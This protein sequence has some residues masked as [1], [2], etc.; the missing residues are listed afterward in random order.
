MEVTAALDG[1]WCR[2]AV[3]WGGFKRGWDEQKWRHEYKP[4]F[5]SVLL[6]RAREKWEVIAPLQC[7]LH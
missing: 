4:L 7:Y 1:K 3:G 6:K 2:Q 5:Q